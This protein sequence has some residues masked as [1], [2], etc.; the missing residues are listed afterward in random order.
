MAVAVARCASG[1]RARREPIFPLTPLTELPILAPDA[2]GSWSRGNWTFSTLISNSIQLIEW[3]R[4]VRAKCD[5]YPIERR[6]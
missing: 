5:D 1:Q 6:R 3:R 2:N 4:M